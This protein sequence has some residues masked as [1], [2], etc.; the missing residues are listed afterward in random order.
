VVPENTWI[1]FDASPPTCGNA[2]LAV[3][4]AADVQ[5]GP[6]NIIT[7]KGS[8][9]VSNG[10]ASCAKQMPSGDAF[11][12]EIHLDRLL[13]PGTK[14]V[15]N[16]CMLTN[17]KRAGLLAISSVNGDQHAP[18]LIKYTLYGVVSS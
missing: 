6:N 7:P 9:W 5:V 12:A 16:V 1:D 15:L 17:Q 2:K 13:P 8:L 18:Y 10:T 14:S 3:P 4:V 11:E